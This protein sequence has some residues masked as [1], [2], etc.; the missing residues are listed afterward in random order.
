MNKMCDLLHTPEQVYGELYSNMGIFPVM[1]PFPFL[2]AN[3][4]PGI[5]WFGHP[6]MVRLCPA[7]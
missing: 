4:F 5:P 1:E 6:V 2:C 3:V 7:A